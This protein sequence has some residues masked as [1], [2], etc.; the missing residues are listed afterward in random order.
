MTKPGRRRNARDASRSAALVLFLAS[1]PAAMMLRALAAGTVPERVRFEKDR[2]IPSMSLR[3]GELPRPGLDRQSRA[4]I[5]LRVAEIAVPE[6]TADEAV[7]GRP[8]ALAFDGERLYVADALDCAVKVFGEDG[9]FRAAFGRK[10]QGPGELSFPSGVC[11]A[12]SVIAVADKLNFRIQLFESGGE[13]R[14]GFKLPFAPDR[15]FALDNGRI[16]VTSNP[17]GPR[18]G[19]R[20]LHAYGLDGHLLWEALGARLSGDPVSAAFANMILLCLGEADD[21]YVLFRSGERTILHYA[22]SGEVL[23]R[24][25]VDER[26]VA[27]EVVMPVGPGGLRL[28]GFCWAA[29]FECGR[30]YLSPPEVLA[31]KDLGPGRTI[32]VFDVAGRLCAVVDLPCPIHRFLVAGGRL[33][34][35]DDE[36]SLRIFDLEVLP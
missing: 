3:G 17:T 32:S 33:F 31:G 13:A 29:A 21:F 9:R 20:M 19:E 7:L 22:D 24:V 15:V 27:R 14:G 2:T 23:G 16:L 26:Y 12:G 1:V 11:C 10:G 35:V 18:A 25:A 36:E 8:L 34:A 30:F 4:V 28:S 5:R 6:E